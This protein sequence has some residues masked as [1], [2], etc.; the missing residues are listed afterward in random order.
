MEI[1]IRLAEILAERHERG[2]GT[3]KK[4]CD[5]TNLERHQVAALLR[6]RAKYVSLETVGALCDFLVSEYD[7][8]P[9]DLPGLLFGRQPGSFWSLLADRQLLDLC[10]GVRYLEE[11]PERA[12]VVAS[13][14]YLQGMLLYG[15][16][17]PGSGTAEDGG[18]RVSRGPQR[19]EQ[20][21]VR[22]PNGNLEGDPGALQ[23]S[24]EDADRVY[25]RFDEQGGD[26][27]LVCLGSPKSNP[28]VER[29]VAGIFDAEPFRSIERLGRLSD[30]RVPFLYRY[31]RDDA[32][33]PSCL[34]GHKLPGLGADALPGIYYEQESGEW[35]CCPWREG[36]EDAALIFFAYRPP[37]GR[38]EMV[39]GGFSARATRCLPEILR[40]DA[41]KLWPPSYDTEELQV[42]AFVVRL[43]FKL[44]QPES[45]MMPADRPSASEVIPLSE[46]VL[47]KRLAPSA[48][49]S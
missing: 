36:T 12:W 11:L 14:S 30:I 13:D 5:A 41:P 19:L 35:A 2:R 10:L 27:A 1:S 28:V 32:K 8:N 31:R 37:E 34:A 16:S 25:S 24:R 48:V 44:D 47:K 49:V 7:V 43:Q 42:G 39:L 33:P 38:L 6:N 45:G 46:A 18:R 17:S 23:P 29:V 40:R 3:I 21:L 4:I 22:S 20:R 9:G 26:R 15:I